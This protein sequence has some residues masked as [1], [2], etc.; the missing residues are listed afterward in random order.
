MHVRDKVAA[1]AMGLVERAWALEPQPWF[2]S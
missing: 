2:K 1:E